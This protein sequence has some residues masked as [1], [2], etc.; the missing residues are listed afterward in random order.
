MCSAII[1]NP[2]LYPRVLFTHIL[3]PA[4][5]LNFNLNESC[6]IEVLQRPYTGIVDIWTIYTLKMM[7]SHSYIASHFLPSFHFELSCFLHRNSRA[8]TTNMCNLSTSFLRLK[9]LFPSRHNQIDAQNILPSFFS[10][11]NNSSLNCVIRDW[12]STD[13]SWIYSISWNV[14]IPSVVIVAVLDKKQKLLQQVH[15]L[16]FDFL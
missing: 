14:P 6:W 11:S 2:A 5:P 15:I 13:T 4:H 12:S 16:G 8:S 1:V 9:W 7:Q 3:V 10:F